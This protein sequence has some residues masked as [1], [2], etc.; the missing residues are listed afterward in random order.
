MLSSTPP[1]TS[2]HRVEF[3]A[4]AE[5]VPAG[6][7]WSLAWQVTGSEVAVSSVQLASASESG[8][9]MIESIPEGGRRQV[10]FARP[11][12]FTFTLTVV[13]H[14]GVRRSRQIRV[15]VTD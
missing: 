11:G 8:L 9:E 1:N 5:Q 4:S 3:S 7:L 10:I 2:F 13:F 6:H 14:D 15:R 12:L